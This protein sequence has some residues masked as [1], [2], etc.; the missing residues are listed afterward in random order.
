MAEDADGPE[1]AGLVDL[2]TAQAEP[3]EPR[4][5]PHV[6]EP[7][8]VFELA[9]WAPDGADLPDALKLAAS[10]EP[11]ALQPAEEPE[12]EIVASAADLELEAMEP[13]TGAEPESA[14]EESAPEES[15]REEPAAAG[16]RIVPVEDDLSGVFSLIARVRSPAGAPALPESG[17]REAETCRPG[18]EPVR[19]K[20]ASDLPLLSDWPYE[21]AGGAPAEPAESGG[22]DGLRRHKAAKRLSKRG[23]ARPDLARIFDS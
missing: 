21:P 14:R 9:G 16:G 11:E 3:D 15:A 2:P 18:S 17:K 23:D 22:D 19:R 1:R 10:A 20:T 5:G 12:L 8:T 6:L 7:G 4:P 13:G